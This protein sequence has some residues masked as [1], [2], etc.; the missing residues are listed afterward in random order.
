MDFTLIA[1]ITP[2]LFEAALV[3]LQLAVFSAVLGIC[4][5]AIL[6]VMRFAR[7]RVI[8][9]IAAVY[10][11]VMR[12]TPLLV[13]L[14]LVFFGG[15]QL[16]VQMTPFQAAFLTMGA[17]I[18]AYMSEGIRGAIM[19]V[20]RGQ[21]EAARTLGFGR[22]RTMWLFILPQ[23][24]PLMLRSIGVNMIIL[25]KSTALASTIGV[26]ELTYSA[27]RFVTSTYRPF[28]VFG[29]AGVAYLIIIGA[30]LLAVRV[31]ERLF[32]AKLGG[33]V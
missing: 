26:I 32:A 17:N 30:L 11:S 2:F 21:T 1:R 8:R 6:V 29:E 13:Q 25:T 15:A 14:F 23:A 9:A 19:A 5:A 4:I 28:E 12:G 20:D 33:Q 18:A 10:V 3:T 27:Q 16:G 24:A 22:A 31:M 7:N